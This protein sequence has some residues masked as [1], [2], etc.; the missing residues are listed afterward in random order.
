MICSVVWVWGWLIAQTLNLHIATV[1]IINIKITTCERCA[2]SWSSTCRRTEKNP[3][4]RRSPKSTRNLFKLNKTLQCYYQVRNVGI[5]IRPRDK[6]TKY[7]ITSLG[8]LPKRKAKMK[9][10]TKSIMS[11]LPATPLYAF[12]IYQRHWG[13]SNRR[14]DLSLRINNRLLPGSIKMTWYKR[15]VLRRFL[16]ICNCILDIFRFS[17]TL[18]LHHEHT[19]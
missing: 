12:V 13:D 18:A 6:A 10:L 17:T 11:M 9:R 3:I 4:E 1:H 19:M 15:W 7:Q 8:V 2:P 5:W 16:N 14:N